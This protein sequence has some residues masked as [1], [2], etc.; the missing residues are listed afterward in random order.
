M[1]RVGIRIP[2]FVTLLAS[3]APALAQADISPT[4]PPPEESN[5]DQPPPV[6]TEAPT[7]QGGR[8]YTPEDFA[9]FAPR[10]ALDMLNQVPGFAIVAA[11]TDQRGLGQATGNVLINGERFSG[12]S[13]DIFTELRRISAANVTRIEI[14][15]GATLNVPGLAGQV[16]NVVTTSRGLS[17][18]YIW[19]PQQRAHR[20]PFRWS[21]G[22][23]SLNGS[24][25]GTEF[26]ASLRNDSFRN[27]NAGPE[28]V[29]DPNDAILDRRDEVLSVNGDQP[30]LSGSL[31]RAFGDGSILNLNGAFGLYH[32]DL[33][34]VSLRSGP[35]QPDR[36]R[37][38]RE[39]EREHNYELGGD[40]EFGLLGGRLKLIG[41]RRFE[42]SP[43]R[44]TLVQ[45]F[46]DGRPTTGQRFTQVA[47]ETETIARAE[48]RWSGGGDWQVSFEGALNRL[49]VENGLFELNG[50]GDFEPLPFPNSAATVQERRAEALLTW[51]RP[52]SPNLNIQLSAGGE[53]SQL[54]QEGAGGL[55]RTFYRPKGFAS[56]A[57]RPASNLDLSARIERQV[58]QLNF[59]DFVASANVSGGFANAGNV[60]LVPPQSWNGQ[61]QATRNLGAWGTAT[62]RVY[63]RLITD[64]VD[65]IPIGAAGQ[66]PGNVDGTA[67]VYGL[68]WTSTFNFD[69][70]GWRGA[71][72]DLNLQFQKTSLEDPLTGLRRPINENM[73][74]QIEVNLRHDVPSSDWAYG[75]SFFQYRQSPLFRLDERWQF[76]DTPGSLGMFVE[77]KDVL[78][79]TVRAGVDNLLGTNESF[80][81]I[82]FDGRRNAAETNVRFIEDR[83]RFYGPVFTLTISGTI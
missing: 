33:E 34:E 65:I 23:V 55:S 69:P 27:G 41:L 80:S 62:G 70:V 58:G 14:V 10:N 81:R 68:Q 8:T 11:D 30:R 38:L 48:Y 36:N 19:R 54:T 71:K 44:Q 18:N 3:T 6:A 67:T 40:Y 1:I 35:G 2:L 45:A 75:A 5:G 64:V 73:T 25:G 7:V 82:F 63:G 60:N 42:H 39:R 78:G 51:G 26:T 47:D 46:A 50:A 53:Y 22:E 28:L 77:H 61:V 17:G 29:T 72:L 59:F 31:R 56:L 21:N 13:T 9:R 49:D 20:T 15:D 66:A 32:I 57:W 43:F 74:R 24:I 12:K 37:N 76:L 52:L 83:D 79:L 4:D 16:A